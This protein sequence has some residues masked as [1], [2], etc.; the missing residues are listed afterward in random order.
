MLSLG[1]YLF[2]NPAGAKSKAEA[3]QHLKESYKFFFHVL[4]EDQKNIYAATGLG[5]VC[6]EKGENEAAREIFS[7]VN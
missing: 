7:K 5:M 3:G 2:A 1:N 6:A 4:N